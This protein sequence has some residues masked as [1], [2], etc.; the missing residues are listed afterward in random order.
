MTDPI[1]RC[2]VHGVAPA[3]GAAESGAEEGEAT[4]G[5][6]E[7]GR[8]AVRLLSGERRRRL[9]KFL[10]GALRHFP[11]DVGLSLS[12]GGWVD[13][14][15]LVA[16]AADR[17]DW[18]DAERVDAVI[19][20]DPKGRFEA[21]AGRVRAAYGH[22]VDVDLDAEDGGAVGNES[23]AEGGGA[24]RSGEATEAAGSDAEEA[25]IPDQ[26]YHGTA[27][28]RAA[29]IEREGLKPMGR[30][31]VHLSGSVADARAVGERHAA[32]P[33]VFVVDAAAM[34]ADGRRIR[35]RGTETYTVDRVPPEYLSRRES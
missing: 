13:R 12:R 8:D 22:S 17:Y 14:T 9:S 25:S 6:P 18:A 3:G 19:A 35:K 24:I 11:G 31:A 4:N 15:D 26:L 27:P 7:C 5:C 16:A 30:Q 32:D 23:T 1:D 20:A 21:S 29:A 34:L 10:S 33:V 28:R 2:P